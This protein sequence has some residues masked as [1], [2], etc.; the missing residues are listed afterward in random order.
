MCKEARVHGTRWKS[1]AKNLWKTEENQFLSSLG[2]LVDLKTR[3]SIR[4][5][6]QMIVRDFPKQAVHLRGKSCA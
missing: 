2:E 5:F 1:P 4:Q 6:M 3:V